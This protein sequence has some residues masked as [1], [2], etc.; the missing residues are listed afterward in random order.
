MKRFLTAL[1][2]LLLALPAL[3]ADL[4][5]VTWTGPDLIGKY[6]GSRRIMRYTA[7]ILSDDDTEG[8]AGTALTST[9]ALSGTLLL[10]EA[11]DG[12]TTP[13]TAWDFTLVNDWGNDV[14]GG[15]G[16][17]VPT[18]GILSPPKNTV[19]TAALTPMP[20]QGTLT[21]S[22][23]N[24]GASKTAKIRLYVAE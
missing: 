1:L 21:L 13:S 10:V 11:R 19:A 2:V 6:D 4:G 3:A 16:A 22:L 15:V 12:A 23:T 5:T 8:V 24:L 17:N 7:T 9:K 20:I 14:L 18:T